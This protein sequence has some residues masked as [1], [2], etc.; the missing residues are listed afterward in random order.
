M[1]NLDSM[2]IF[3]HK[4]ALVTT[5]NNHYLYQKTSKTFPENIDLIAIDGTKGLFGI[6][7]IKFMFK[8]LSS[9]KYSWIIM[10]DEDVLF[11]NPKSVFEIIGKMIK[12]NIDVCSIRDGGVLSWRDKNPY[13]PNPFFCILN[14]DK[15][16]SLYSE[17]EVVENQFLLANEFDDDLSSLNFKYDV[18]SI[19]EEYYCFFLWL[20]RKKMKFYFLHAVSDTFENDLET[21]TVFDFNGEIL[22]YHTW[23]ARMYGVSEFHTK[24]IDRIVNICVPQ[25]T[26]D[27]I[28]VLWLKNYDFNFRKYFRKIKN[29]ILNKFK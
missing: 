14:F 18:D 17:K 24:R 6:E 15:I 10:V 28:R 9:K 4:I 2:N 12:Y 20:R 8:K 27:K 16:K 5:V 21:T 13:L 7:S 22:L 26:Q 19:F 3:L 11:A 29:R 23:Y 1:K 25:I